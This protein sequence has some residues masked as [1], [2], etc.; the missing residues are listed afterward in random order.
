MASD[1]KEMKIA[2]LAEKITAHL[3]RF[4]NDPIINKS[5]KYRTSPYQ[6]AFAFH[7]GRYVGV[8]YVEFQGPSYLSRDEAVKYLA[9]LDAGNVGRHWKQQGA[10]SI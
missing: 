8:T 6:R 5:G 7:T 3:K 1:T 4:E 2:E 10:Q 9:W